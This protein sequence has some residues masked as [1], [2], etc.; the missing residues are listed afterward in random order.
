MLESKLEKILIGIVVGSIV[1]IGGF[2][3]T[4]DFIYGII[5]FIVSGIII[6]F[7]FYLIILYRKLKKKRK[8]KKIL[9]LLNKYPRS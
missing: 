8:N 3:L 5:Y 2:I 1:T 7:L 9:K 6:T 4:I